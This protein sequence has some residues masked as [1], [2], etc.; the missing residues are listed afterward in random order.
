MK[1]CPF[2]GDESEAT[3]QWV[4]S[5]EAENAKLRA[6]L[7]SVKEWIM[8]PFGPEDFD[9][10]AIHPAFNKALKLTHKALAE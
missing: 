7:V 3:I 5:A 6:A 4:R 10:K 2:S 9:S 1:P 8:D